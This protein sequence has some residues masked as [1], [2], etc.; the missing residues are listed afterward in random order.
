MA[1]VPP[2]T[3]TESGNL[4]A[5]NRLQAAWSKSLIVTQSGVPSGTL[6]TVRF[7]LELGRKILV[8]EPQKGADR[9]AYAGNYQLISESVFDS[10]ILGGSK[11]F[12]N[13]ISKKLP[14]A[15]LVIKNPEDYLNYIKAN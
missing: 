6:H 7:A 8:L 5:R 15:D 12:Q 14:C 10:K 11:V 2:G 13:Q 3:E 4:I 1:E 9:E